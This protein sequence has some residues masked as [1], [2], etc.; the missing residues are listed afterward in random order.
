MLNLMGLLVRCDFTFQGTPVSTLRREMGDA[1]APR[2]VEYV[3]SLLTVTEIPKVVLFAHHTSVIDYLEEKLSKF[4]VVTHTGRTSPINKHKA[5]IEFS[6]G[7][8]R[9]F[10]GQLDTMEGVDGLQSVSS[11]V[12]FAEPAWTPGRN[13]QCVDRC[14]RIGQHDNVVAHFLLVE[15]SFNEKVLNVVLEKAVDIH[16]TLDR[17]LV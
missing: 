9:V 17:R 5:K 16:E 3:T 14:H 8:P 11:D 2:V 6:L 12:V 1:M 10:L 13:E 7:T 4:G 15:G